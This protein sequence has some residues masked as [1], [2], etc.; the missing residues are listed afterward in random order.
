MVHLLNTLV[1]PRSTVPGA[2]D[3]GVAEFL[4]RTRRES[5]RLAEAVDTVLDA[6][7]QPDKE[8]ELSEEGFEELLR[9]TEQRYPEEF[10]TV[11]QAVYVG[12]YG[13]PQVLAALSEQSPRGY[14][15]PS[16]ATNALDGVRSRGPIFRRG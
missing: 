15:H 14:R 3:L 13:H 1:P 8:S 2:G 7:S 10:N 4:D 16:L 6:L 5:G 9:A 12:Y 11:L